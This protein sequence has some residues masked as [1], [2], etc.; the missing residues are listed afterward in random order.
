MRAPAGVL[1]AYRVW[2]VTRE[3]LD[4]L[5]DADRVTLDILEVEAT[6][7]DDIIGDF[8]QVT[9]RISNAGPSV[10]VPDQCHSLQVIGPSSTERTSSARKSGI[11]VN[12]AAQ[13]ARICSRPVNV[14]PGWAGCELR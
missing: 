13:L 6:G 11:P 5:I 2:S 4:D 1:R 14:R 8:E 3:R 12:M 10:R 9:P 7:H